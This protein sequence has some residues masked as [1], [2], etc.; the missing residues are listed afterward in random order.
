MLL[1]PC[2]KLFAAKLNSVQKKHHLQPKARDAQKKKRNKCNDVFFF[3]SSFYYSLSLRWYI[4]KLL[5]SRAVR[6]G[7]W[8][9]KVEVRTQSRVW[10]AAAVIHSRHTPWARSCSDT[11]PW[12]VAR[13]GSNGECS[14]SIFTKKKA[15]LRQSSI[16]GT[17]TWSPIMH[18]PLARLLGADVI[19][20]WIILDLILFLT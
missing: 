14:E 2:W 1:F 18:F 9:S 16:K 5:C 4:K 11:R 17:K 19:T 15:E 20:I 12:R 13:V 3:F 10:T 7:C 8:R 6:G